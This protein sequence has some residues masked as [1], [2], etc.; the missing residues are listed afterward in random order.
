M[1]LEEKR[2]NPLVFE[3]A[4]REDVLQKSLVLKPFS[5]NTY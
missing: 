5:K 2:A 4:G 1:L 3:T